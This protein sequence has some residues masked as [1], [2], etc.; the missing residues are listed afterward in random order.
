MTL[1]IQ[2]DLMEIGENFLTLP[3]VSLPFRFF[4]F[5]FFLYLNILQPF[6]PKPHLKRSTADQ[7]MVCLNGNRFGFFKQVIRDL[8]PSVTPRSS[9]FSNICKDI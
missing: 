7:Y 3:F 2:Q 6:L 4:S 8:T 9:L 1:G 5:F